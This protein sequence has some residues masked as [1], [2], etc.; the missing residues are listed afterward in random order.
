[1]PRIISS[2]RNEPHSLPEEFHWDSAS[3]RC[4]ADSPL[5]FLSLS[6]DF[7][8]YT[9]RQQA[10]ELFS[11]RYAGFITYS[12]HFYAFDF[13]AWGLPLQTSAGASG[14]SWGPSSPFTSLLFSLTPDRTAV[15]I[16]APT[17][18]SRGCSIFCMVA[19]LPVTAHASF[20]FLIPH[21]TECWYSQFHFPSLFCSGRSCFLASKIFPSHHHV[22]RLS[23]EDHQ[24][25]WRLLSSLITIL[26]ISPSARCFPWYI[27]ISS[28]ISPDNTFMNMHNKLSFSILATFSLLLW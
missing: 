24:T 23:D 7:L 14:I 25:A 4:R 10:H 28:S 9:T 21:I 20:K 2:S 19:A 18:R 13:D 15:L 12:P 5:H 26:N 6:T 17:A 16:S 1:M 3:P 11:L 27:N 22:G 8:M